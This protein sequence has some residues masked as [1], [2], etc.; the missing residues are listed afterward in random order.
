MW[1]K[2]HITNSSHIDDFYEHYFSSDV[3]KKQYILGSKN[4]IK[5]TTIIKKS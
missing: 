4:E 3:N 1:K 5:Y 2:Y